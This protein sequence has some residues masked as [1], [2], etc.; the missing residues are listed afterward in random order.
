MQVRAPLG[1]GG[2]E[3]PADVSR[4]QV[5]CKS[6]CCWRRQDSGGSVGQ[7]RSDF[8]RAGSCHYDLVVLVVVG[9]GEEGGGACSE[10]THL[11]RC[12]CVYG[13]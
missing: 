5:L 3:A 7:R 12:V 1:W 8:A 9:G 4:Y 11:L 10:T 13:M 6:D 2:R